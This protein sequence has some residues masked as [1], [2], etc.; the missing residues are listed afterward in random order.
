MFID[1]DGRNADV[2]ELN[3]DNGNLTKVEENDKVDE[4]YIVDNKGNRK[5]DSAG[6]QVKFTMKGMNK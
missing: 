6:N 4:L 2:W 5:T 3:S 1:P